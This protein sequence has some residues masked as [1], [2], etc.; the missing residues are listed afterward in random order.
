MKKYFLLLFSLG[1]LSSCGTTGI[2]NSDH[3]SLHFNS[4]DWL[5]ERFKRNRTNPL[6]VE[7]Q[8]T[9]KEKNN[10]FVNMDFKG[11]PQDPLRGINPTAVSI[12]SFC[13]NSYVSNRNGH[14]AWIF[15]MKEG[16]YTKRK[17][18]YLLIIGDYKA[19]ETIKK[20]KTLKWSKPAHI[21]KNAENCKRLLKE[22][23]HW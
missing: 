5:T 7:V 10:F 21:E 16:D 17:R 20:N 4:N 3:N 1:L 14:N 2:K 13:I 9:P 15:G 12:F 6:N 22:E 8:V 18:S 23:Y 19:L 11:D